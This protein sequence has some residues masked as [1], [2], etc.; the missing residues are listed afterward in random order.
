[1][2]KIL[3]LGDSIR[4]GYDGYVKEAFKDVAEVYAPKEN[5]AF[6]QYMLR[7]VHEWKRREGYPDDIDLVHWNASAWD[8]LRIMG[9]D[10]FTSPE[11]YRDN[12]RRLE[13]RLRVLFPEAKQ[14]FATG[15]SVIEEGYEP[16]YQRYNAD[17]E[18]FNQIAIE[19]L[20]PFGV[21]INDLYSL[22]KSAPS[23]CRSDMTHF[24][25]I[26]GI[27]LVGEKVVKTICKELDIPLSKLKDVSAIVPN[28]SKEIMGL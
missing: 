18:R 12:L 26:E 13:K 17:I 25:T 16:P 2:K 24:Y 6:S 11:T 21:G 20:T 9:D 14:V 28:I 15:T 10:T 23:S 7:W 19:T 3:L 8:V 5:C 1:M 4:L 27:K 22:T